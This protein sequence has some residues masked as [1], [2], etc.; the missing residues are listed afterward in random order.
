MSQHQLIGVAAVEMPPQHI[1]GIFQHARNEIDG[2]DQLAAEQ[3][4]RLIKQALGSPLDA[5]GR[6]RGDLIHQRPRAQGS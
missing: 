2:I 5:L 3:H 4:I 1:P 6:Q